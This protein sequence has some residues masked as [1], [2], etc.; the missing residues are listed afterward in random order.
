MRLKR[1]VILLAA[2]C[3]VR[4]AYA[5]EDPL[6]DLA[7]RQL[8]GSLERDDLRSRA[9]GRKA[10]YN[11]YLP[12][13]YRRERERRYPLVIMLHGLFEN[14]DR[15][16]TR[17]GPQMVEDAINAK[18]VPPIIMCVP[19]G[20]RGL[21]IDAKQG[22]TDRWRTFLLEELIPHVEGKWR[23][24]PGRAGRRLIGLSS[25]GYGALSIAL[26]KP[27]FFSAV[28]VHDPML[29]PREPKKLTAPQKALVSHTFLDDAFKR[30]YGDPLEPGIWTRH[31]PETLAATL[32]PDSGLRIRIEGYQETRHG[33][34]AGAARLHE[35]LKKRGV[36]HEYHVRPG[37]PGW[38]A[39]REYLASSL[40]FLVG[41]GKK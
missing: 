4:P 36:Q 14:E 12:A 25:G 24:A 34:L 28:A 9:L 41:D 13:G 6:E 39:L 20:G 23:T 17:G 19:E 35:T 7:R 16:L 21:W 2:L 26:A 40:R 33:F 27:A 1:F 5:Q 10:R 31:H 8:K 15:W 30:A 32:E 3:T 38:V 29:L 11:L 37:R 22:R 18:T